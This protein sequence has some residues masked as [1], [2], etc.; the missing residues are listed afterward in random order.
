MEVVFGWILGVIGESGLGKLMLVFSVLQLLLNGVLLFGWI[1]LVGQDILVLFEVDF[2]CICGWDVGMVFQELMMV[3]NLLKIIGVQV[4]EMILVYEKVFQCEV[5]L[6][7]VEV[8]WWVELLLE[9]FFL[10]WYLYELFGGQCQRVVIVMVIVLKLK[11]LIVDELIIVLDVIMQVQIFQFFKKLVS[12]DGMGLMLISYDFV[13]V[14][15]FV[16]DL[17]IMCYGEVVE[18]GL[19][20][21]LFGVMKY[22]YLKVLFEVFGY[23]LDR[24]G[25]M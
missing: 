11:L 3:F 17:V 8:L 14:V 20:V 16:D 18:S 10:F 24:V 19:V 6:R 13:V 2:C 15:D 7:V 5:F 21:D 22:F 4:V 25:V 1:M 23:V 9:K 12:E